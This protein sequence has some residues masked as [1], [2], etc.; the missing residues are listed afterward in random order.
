MP[1]RSALQT[2]DQSL[3]QVKAG[4]TEVEEQRGVLDNRT[5]L[6]SDGEDHLGVVQQPGHPFEVVHGDPEVEG[7]M[8]GDFLPGITQCRLGLGLDRDRH[9]GAG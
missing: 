4:F 5:D 9:A 2:R 7:H 3:Q 6:R 1:T 8:H